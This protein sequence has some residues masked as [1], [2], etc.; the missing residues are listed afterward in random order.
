RDEQSAQVQKASGWSPAEFEKRLDACFDLHL[1]EGSAE[2]KMH[3]LFAQFL[4]SLS[5][6]GDQAEF[7]KQVRTVQ[8]GR[9]RELAGQVAD[10]PNRTDLASRL[11]TFPL[12]P[13]AWEEFGA[14]IAIDAGETA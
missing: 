5:L 2:L 12:A 14:P 9:F 13:G 1:L 11:I 6:A 4:Q 3:Q 8:A 10:H 7:L